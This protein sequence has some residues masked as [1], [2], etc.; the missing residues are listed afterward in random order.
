MELFGHEIGDDITIS[1]ALNLIT[2]KSESVLV[3][4]IKLSRLMKGNEIELKNLQNVSLEFI[5]AGTQ[6]L[7]CSSASMLMH[8]SQ[9]PEVSCLSVI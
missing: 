8:L 9:H 6:S 7:Q 4:I 3:N 2:E 5:F 1:E